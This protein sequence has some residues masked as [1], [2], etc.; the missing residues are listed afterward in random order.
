M[1]LPNVCKK[2]MDEVIEEF[3]DIGVYQTG[4]SSRYIVE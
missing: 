1:S 4:F 2:T 3:I